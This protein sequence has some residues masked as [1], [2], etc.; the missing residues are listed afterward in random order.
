MRVVDRSEDYF[1]SSAVGY[2]GEK[3]PVNG[4][5]LNLHN[6]YYWKSIIVNTEIPTALLGRSHSLNEN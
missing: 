1:F 6:L 5:L 4:Y 3:S 2:A